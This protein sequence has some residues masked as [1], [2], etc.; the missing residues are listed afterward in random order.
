[1]DKKLTAEQ[2]NTMPKEELVD[3]VLSMQ[4][5]L[6]KLNSRMDYLLEQ[7]ALANSQR[8]GR[9]TEKLAQIDGQ[10]YFGADGQICFNE[11]EAI[12]DIYPDPEEPT[13][14]SAAG[15]RR[16]RPRGKK[17]QDLSV[18]PVLQLPTIEV[19]EEELLESMK[20]FL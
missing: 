1:M 15:K 5:Q 8:F 19:P 11:A 7:V 10:G 9:H 18:F 13:V 12:H 6:S 16:P 14:E 3:A 2:L 20:V 4:D 17:E